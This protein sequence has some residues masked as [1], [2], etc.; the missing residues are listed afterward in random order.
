[1]AYILIMNKT[2]ELGGKPILRTGSGKAG[3]VITDNGNFILDVD[4]GTVSNPLVLD[5]QLKSI[6]GIV[7]TGLFCNMAKEAY[8]GQADETVKQKTVS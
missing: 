1:M 2:R 7:E 6:P 8:I 5:Q 3:P 4:F